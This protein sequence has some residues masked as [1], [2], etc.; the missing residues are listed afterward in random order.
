MH[1]LVRKAAA[2]EINKQNKQLAMKL[3]KMRGDDNLTKRSLDLSFERQLKA[4]NLLCKLP[5]V[6]MKKNS[7]RYGGAE[8]RGATLFAKPAH[9]RNDS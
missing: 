6:D 9:T 5:I 7:F 4:K 1:E 8:M 3:I 2:D